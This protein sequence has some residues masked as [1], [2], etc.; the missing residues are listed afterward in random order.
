MKGEVIMKYIRPYWD[1]A[2]ALLLLWCIMNG[3]F[4]LSTL[5]SGSIASLV[6]VIMVRL[7]FSNNDHVKNYRVP[8]Y[9]F[10]WF[11]IVL[12]FQIIKSA[13]STVISISKNNID[14]VIIEL[15]T[16]INNHWFQCLVA[17]SITLTPGTVT[18]DKTDHHLIILWLYPTTHDKKAQADAIFGPFEKILK[19]GDNY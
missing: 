14:P 18:I 13:I 17:N 16:S 6:T 3:S 8:L 11:F 7:L 5:I 9:L 1:T 12:I 4:G 10:L 15:D 2:L 19:R